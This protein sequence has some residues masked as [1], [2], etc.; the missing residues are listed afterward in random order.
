MGLTQKQNVKAQDCK[1]CLAQHEGDAIINTRVEEE[2]WRFLSQQNAKKRSKMWN[3]YFNTEEMA[4]WGLLSCLGNK[5][6]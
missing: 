3:F 1:V 5:P 2:L 4:L 6:S